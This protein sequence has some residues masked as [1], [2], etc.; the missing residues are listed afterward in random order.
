MKSVLKSVLVAEKNSFVRAG[1]IREVESLPDLKVVG[2]ARDCQEARDLCDELNPAVV[3]MELDLPKGDGLSLLHALI[4]RHAALR[5][6]VLSERENPAWVR[7]AFRAGA[8]GDVSKHDEPVELRRALRAVCDRGI[9]RGS[10]APILSPR[11]ETRLHELNPGREAARIGVLSDRELE[12]F[13]LIGRKIGSGEIARKLFISVRTVE[14]HQGHIKEKLG[15]PDAAQLHR[16]AENWAAR[17]GGE[18]RASR[19]RWRGR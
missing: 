11:I 6:V 14:S 15:L 19:R 3:V 5:A 13:L 17:E 10:R 9:E 7:R 18:S 2:E 4:L 12:I 16:Q 8:S 1:I